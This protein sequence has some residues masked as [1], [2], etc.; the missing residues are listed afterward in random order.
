MDRSGAMAS[1]PKIGAAL[2]QA[3]MHY[4]S[5]NYWPKFAEYNQTRQDQLDRIDSEE[6]SSDQKKA[7]IYF[8]S[9]FFI[10]FLFLH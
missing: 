4:P 6:N 1:L 10:F 8:I 3:S 2:G 7:S 9:L 5:T